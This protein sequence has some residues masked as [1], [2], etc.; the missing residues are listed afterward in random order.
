MDRHSSEIWA[1]VRRYGAGEFAHMESDTQAAT[2]FIIRDRWIQ[3]L[4]AMPAPK[5]AELTKTEA[6][7][8]RSAS[9]VETAREPAYRSRWQA[10]ALIIEAQFEVVEVG[11]VVFED[12]PLANTVPPGA[13]IA[14]GEVLPETMRLARE[15]TALDRS[16][17]CKRELVLVS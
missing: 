13:S 5:A 12:E 6:G 7:A 17:V 16:A 9:A 11:I 8:D 15:K 10:R 4:L 1:T 14:F 3:L 2:Y